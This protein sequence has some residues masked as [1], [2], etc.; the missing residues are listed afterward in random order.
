MNT[1]EVPNSSSG[2]AQQ[3]SFLCDIPRGR[4]VIG[5]VWI[6]IGALALAVNLGLRLPGELPQNWWAV[7]IFIGSATQ[8]ERAL[9][10]YRLIGR[11]DARVVRTALTALPPA[12]IAILFLLGLSLEVWWP[13][14][15]VIGGLFAMVPGR[16]ARCRD[17]NVG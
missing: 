11:V 12:V 3:P 10:Q 14:F 9:A 5:A 7:F 17:R 6:L 2:I 13:V 1:N 16:R 8:I 4:M 15:I